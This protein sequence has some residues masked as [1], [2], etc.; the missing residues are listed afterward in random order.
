MEYVKNGLKSAVVVGAGAI[1]IELALALN[2]KGVDVHLVDIESSPVPNLADNDMTDEIRDE[3]ARCGIH[4]HLGVKVTELRGDGRVS[5]VVMDN[6]ASIHLKALDDCSVNENEDLGG[7]V[8]FAVGVKPSISLVSDTG[9]E[10]GRDGIIVN[11]RMETN[12]RDVYAVG[13]C[14][15]FVSGISRKIIPG[16]LA[17][18]A[19]PMAKVLAHNLLGKDRCYPGF[20]N[21]AATKIGKLYIGGTGFTENAAVKAGFD[22][23]CGHSE[24]TTK[25]PIMPGAEKIRIKLVADKQTHRL[26]GAQIV[27]GEPV[28]GRIDLLTFAIQK[29]STIEDLTSLSYSSQPYQSFFPAAN[30]IV[31]AAEEIAGK[32]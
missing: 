32:F 13:D 21:G 28:T 3:I 19:V 14:V 8:I 12:I 9:L 23:V 20:Y 10:F 25:F 15:Q 27:S 26:I 29:E 11:E 16:K 22:V 24:V 31:L 7:V 5:E 6:G 4:L 17:T 1:G 18:N 30:G 2:A